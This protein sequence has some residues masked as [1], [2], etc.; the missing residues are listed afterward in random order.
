MEPEDEIQETG[1]MSSPRSRVPVSQ[2]EVSKRIAT[3]KIKRLPPLRVDQLKPKPAPR[4]LQK[5]NFLQAP[6]GPAQPSPYIQ[7]SSKVILEVPKSKQV[8][9]LDL[10]TSFKDAG[11][12]KNSQ[13]TLTYTNLKVAVPKWEP[14][15]PQKET[16]SNENVLGGSE[17]VMALEVQERSFNSR[18]SVPKSYTTVIRPNKGSMGQVDN[19]SSQ[20]S[21]QAFSPR[22]LNP[23]SALNLSKNANSPKGS[24]ELD[25][26][27]TEQTTSPK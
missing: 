7:P 25:H 1:L 22:R 19:S 23:N 10:F 13:A 5:Q 24:G 27:Q 17:R 16:A 3:Q 21:S 20:V 12:P 8:G 18:R 26:A 2:V 14:P 15:L 11:S 9:S 4:Q 6:Q